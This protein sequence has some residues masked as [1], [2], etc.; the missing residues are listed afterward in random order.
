MI[1][2][3]AEVVKVKRKQVWLKAVSDNKCSG[4]NNPQS[5][6]V[7]LL[8]RYFSEKLLKSE[9]LIRLH[10]DLALLPGERV[11]LG[12]S[13]KQ[14]L[15][16]SALVYF[17]PVLLLLVFGLIGHWL[18]QLMGLHS[19]IFQILLTLTGIVAAYLLIHYLLAQA[20]TP[21]GRIDP[22]VLRRL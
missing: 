6:G 8:S 16:S 20:D 7:G 4:C 22:V 15:L 9:R 12:I 3:V 2:Q 10:S 19:E 14:F 13:E 5:C 18:S 11:L 17:V 21:A 1:E